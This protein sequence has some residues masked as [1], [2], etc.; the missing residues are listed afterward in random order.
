MTTETTPQ[1]Q[2]GDRVR[3]KPKTAAQWIRRVPLKPV[4]FGE[5]R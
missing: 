3:V 2:I 4:V 5:V 1:F